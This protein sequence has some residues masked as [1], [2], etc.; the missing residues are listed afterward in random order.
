MVRWDVDV[1]LTQTEFINSMKEEIFQLPFTN[2]LG[3]NVFPAATKID[4]SYLIVEM[5]DGTTFKIQATK[6]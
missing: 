1:A 3:E 6:V 4:G 5:S 2:C